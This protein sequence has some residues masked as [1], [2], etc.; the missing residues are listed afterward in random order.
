MQ[1][2][3]KIELLLSKKVYLELTVK[4]SDD[5]RDNDNLLSRFGYDDK[6]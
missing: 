5:W 2:R 6:M 1:A 4:V 3:K